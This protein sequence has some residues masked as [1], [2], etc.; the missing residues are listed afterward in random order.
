MLDLFSGVDASIDLRD[1]AI[2]N[3]PIGL[4]VCR[5]DKEGRLTSCSPI[6]E[7]QYPIYP[8]WIELS[9]KLYPTLATALWECHPPKDME[10]AMPRAEWAP[11]FWQILAEVPFGTTISYGELAIRNGLGKNM[12]RAVGRLLG[13]NPIFILYPCHR[14]IQADGGLASFRWGVERKKALIRYESSL[15][16]LHEKR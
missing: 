15:L 8:E 6:E 14:V 9:Q 12:S 10:V 1:S 3:S 16:A 2:L 5:F 13:T 4:V 7:T 11:N